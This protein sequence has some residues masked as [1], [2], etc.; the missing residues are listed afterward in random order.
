MPADRTSAAPPGSTRRFA[1]AAFALTCLTLAIYLTWGRS[2]FNYDDRVEFINVAAPDSLA[3]TLK[4]FGEPSY[5][6]LPYYRPVTK[7]S[8]LLQKSIFGLNPLAF[9]LV[10]ALL[11]AAA[12]VAAY[13]L[14]TVA[15][16][17]IPRPLALLGAALFIL[18]P[19]ASS[20]VYPASG[21]RYSLLSAVFMIGSLAAFL[22][23][24]RRFQ[25]LATVLFALALLSK[26]QSV[27]L[28]PLFLL[29]DWLGL[30]AAAPA[31]KSPTAWLRR[32]FVPGA[33]FTGY[34][35]ARFFVFRGVHFDLTLFPKP[36]VTLLTPVY[37]LQTAV[38]PTWALAYE[39]MEAATW[40]SPTRLFVT[41]A[42]SAGLGW[43]VWRQAPGTGRIAGFWLGLFLLGLLPS[44]NLVS[45]D[46][47]YDERYTCMSLL[48]VIG[49][50]GLAADHAWKNPARRKTWLAVGGAL[51]IAAGATTLNRG[52]YFADDLTFTRQWVKTSP[53]EYLPHYSLGVA[54]AEQGQANAAM[55]AYR[56]A[57]T[58][59]PEW[60]DTH[61]NLGALH[62]QRGEP[63]EALAGFT[64]YVRLKPQSAK[65]HYSLGVA[66]LLLGD[67]TAARRDFERALAL[68]PRYAEAH[69]NLAVAC[70]ELGRTAEA[71]AHY[72][73]ALQI[74]PAKKNSREN[75]GL[76]LRQRGP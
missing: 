73:A 67:Y 12:A 62:L 2:G 9:H 35:V 5:P 15:T 38:A 56:R 18:H 30:S 7:A 51:L 45:Q 46:V 68:Q 3:T 29:A 27:I 59:N 58:L 20:C 53:S 74:D 16:L 63:H 26:E 76:L 28:L 43:T 75:L 52:R 36:V 8:L 42:F 60:P 70:Q 54:L 19:I 69:H 57:L 13:A 44:A 6:S 55:A 50:T 40:F 72:Q 34:F 61:M 49:M 47:A 4:L 24:G 71:I 10:N 22:R 23:A 14:L 39:P 17:R 25:V 48:A 21:G 32:Y 64:H 65:A 33:I 66:R 11:G 37:A 41:V 31:R 1:L